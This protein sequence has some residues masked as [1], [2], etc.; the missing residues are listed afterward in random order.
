MR[1]GEGRRHHYHSVGWGQLALPQPKSVIAIGAVACGEIDT[2]LLGQ[3][4]IKRLRLCQSIDFCP[5]VVP[6]HLTKNRTIPA[7]SGP[8]R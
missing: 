7:V 5:S 4:Q 3:G 1:I 2:A 8:L 6:L